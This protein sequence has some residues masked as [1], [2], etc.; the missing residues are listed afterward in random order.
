M[1]LEHTFRL[2]RLLACALALFAATSLVAYAA[3]PEQVSSKI[4]SAIN[5]TP[6]IADLQVTLEGR[7]MTAS[8]K[9]HR[10]P[11]DFCRLEQ[12]EA[13]KLTSYYVEDSSSAVKIVPAEKRAFVIPGR[14]ISALFELI[15]L[16]LDSSTN[17]KSLRVSQGKSSGRKM[18]IVKGSSDAASFTL[19]V[20]AND[21]LPREYNA[22]PGRGKP[23]LTMRL[24]GLKTVSASDFKGGFFAVPKG[25]REIGR[26]EPLSREDTERLRLF[27]IRL[28]GPLY[29]EQK[30]APGPAA[31]Q[32][33]GSGGG[34][35]AE[36]WLPVLP[37]KMPP[38][39]VI[40][41]ITPLYF[42]GNLLYH[43]KL[44]EP[45]QLK[46]VSIFETQHEKMLEDFQRNPKDSSAKLIVKEYDD[47]GIY[48]II[49]SDDLEKRQLDDLFGSFS[50]QPQ[51]AVDLI[52]K[53]LANL[54]RQ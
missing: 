11:P 18:L 9:L 4:R 43:V 28:R 54:L 3:D 5:G 1:R 39:F 44:V 34:G 45:G 41:T 17:R 51:L 6:F 50:Y 32:A 37:M 26:R 15:N 13:G 48:V 19:V 52:N 16:S 14:R 49:L 40:D 36:V 27:Q 21:Y 31:E 29:G 30:R 42:S 7:G 53:A 8:G 10:L 2:Y 20:D 38:G 22:S 46:L 23:G 33:L 24:S 35:V 12:Y 25:Y 47:S